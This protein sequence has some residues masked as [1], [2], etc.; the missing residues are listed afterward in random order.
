MGISDT[1]CETMIDLS[2]STSQIVVHKQLQHH[3]STVLLS[4]KSSL[5]M[6]VS[7]TTVPGDH[8]KQ[9]QDYSPN[10]IVIVNID[11]QLAA[12]SDNNRVGS[13]NPYHNNRRRWD[14]NSLL[15][16]QKAA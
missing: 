1:H 5:I 3:P 15:P 14:S 16:I 2:G 4:N 12:R 7:Q 8:D 9:S 13:S 6:D 11:D 10:P